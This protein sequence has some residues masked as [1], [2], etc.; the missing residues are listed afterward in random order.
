MANLLEERERFKL[1]DCS[2]IE[3]EVYCK[4]KNL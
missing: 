1:Q 2:P 3:I 4:L